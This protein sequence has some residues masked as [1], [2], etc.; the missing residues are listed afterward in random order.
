VNDV[1]WLGRFLVYWVERHMWIVGG[2]VAG[3]L[4]VY[5]LLNRKGRVARDSDRMIRHLT[6]R[7]RGRYSD[8][9][10]PR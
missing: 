7:S 1:V 10:P 2:A 4:L 3:V 5:W 6:D 9:R 8:L